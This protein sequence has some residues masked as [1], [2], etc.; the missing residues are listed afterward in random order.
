MR[1]TLAGLRCADC[2]A[3]I[4]K[5]LRKV[6]GL[7]GA[8]IN[9]ADPV[10]DLPPELVP[11]VR[12]I[13]ARLEPDVRLVARTAGGP[14]DEE[15]AAGERKR[16]CLIGATALLLAG[17]FFFKDF[18]RQT[19]FSWAEYAVFGAAYLLAGANVIRAALKNLVYG[20]V[21]DENLLL[22][23]ATA[24]AIAI[25]QL[26][27]AV[28]VML[29][30]AVG[31]YLQERAVNRSRRSVAA[32]LEIRPDYANLLLNGE[33]RRVSPEEVAVGQFIVIRP[34]ERVPLDGEVVDGASYVDASALTGEAVP[35]KVEKGEKILA[36]MINGQG[37]LTVRVT[38]PYRESSVARILDLVEKAAA[39]KAPTEQ[40]ITAFTR[41]YTPAVVLGAL[42]LAVVPPLVFPG[43]ALS[44]WIYRAL[45]LLVISCPCA[46]VIS[47]PLG[48]F[49]G[50]GGASRRG[51]LVKGANFLDALAALHT[52]VFD[53]TG[54]LTRGVFR[55]TRAVPANGF[56]EAELLALAA[57]AGAY[58]NH[59]IARSVREAYGREIPPEAVDTYR[60]IPGYGITAVVGGRR[61][62]A[63]SERLL[64]REGIAHE[65]GDLAGT[66]VYVAV[67]GIFAGYLVISD[68]LK[69]DAGE[70]VSRLKELGVR[71][72]VMLT[73]DGEAA[74]RRVAASL[75]LDACFA[76]LL[77]E[78]KVKKVEE[79]QAALPDRR[80]QKL[81]FVGDG[82]NDAPVLA[83]ADVG[84]AMGA[85]GSDAAIEAADVVL[86]ED[87]PSK[88]ATA[89]R[90][91]RHTRR[92]VRQ[93][94]VLALGVKG[95]FLVLGAFGAATIWEAVFADVGVALLAIFNAVRTLRY[96]GAEG[97]KAQAGL[98][99]KKALA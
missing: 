82:I 81:A 28:A 4:E 34:G 21:F 77:P 12:E 73:G 5:E 44:E 74:A 62:L 49:G 50:I 1:Y 65:I 36:G 54:T 66:G 51:I 16:L 15:K 78:D 70:A 91:A 40:F 41:F 96:G 57:H 71:R 87:A 32:L 67:D 43:A 63:G 3:R 98:P 55:V 38:R 61:V 11:A 13:I 18:L 29:F 35:R 30:Y 14:P 42:L 79:L 93:N 69:P 59:P 97:Q 26:T 76:G 6:K 83:R 31:K 53:K 58:S 47:I 39:R 84:V 80:R 72:M 94:V 23:V 60:E 2:A 75:G 95:F 68:E 7:E 86:M 99:S 89:V 22:S 20:R 9:L 90:I 88:L 85:L 52:V 33:T 24:G 25:N 27:E 64:H 46:L 48:Y 45:V 37:L 17:G 19:P 92:V 56:S 8:A 10:L